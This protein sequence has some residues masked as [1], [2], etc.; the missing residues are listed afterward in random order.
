MHGLWKPAF[1]LVSR[2]APWSLLALLGLWR[3]FRRPATDPIQRGLERYLAAYLLAGLVLF[4]IA[5]HQRA[6]HVLP[7]IPAAAILA[8]READRLLGR[9]SATVL[10]W[11]SV[12]GLIAAAV[13]CFGFFS[14][15]EPVVRSEGLRT[16]ARHVEERWSSS[17]PIAF[18]DTPMGLQ[19]H[20]GKHQPTLT[21]EM[22]AASRPAPGTV[23]VASVAS[24]AALRAAIP[25]LA[26]HDVPAWPSNS[27]GAWWEAAALAEPKPK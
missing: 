2:F 17:R 27:S 24:M 3:V 16:F 23:V 10:A 26:I 21:V 1:Y 18:V 7:L 12:I 19:F 6:D 4:G 5:T 22:V 14:K 25:E 11:A 15:Q 20:L 9:R 8:G 13:Y